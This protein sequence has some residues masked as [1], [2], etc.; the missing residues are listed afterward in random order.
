LI[1]F[2]NYKNTLLKNYSIRLYKPEDYALWNTFVN[3]SKNGTFLFNRDFMEYHHDR[4]DDFSLLIFDDK[5]KLVS[6]LP[7]NIKEETV[8]SHQGLTYGGLLFDGKIKITE[9]IEVF[10]TVML[11]LHENK[12]K[13]LNV[14]L[15][16]SVYHQKPANEIAYVLFLANAKL[17]RCD[18]LSVIDL[19]E[20]IAITSGRKEGIKKAEKLN[21][22]I[23][24]ESNFDIFWNQIL[25]PNLLKKHQTKPIHTLEEI[26]KLKQL[27]PENIRQFNVYQ[28]DRIVAGTTIFESQNV[29]HAQYI[30]GN[31]SK[32]ENG[33]L[34]FLYHELITKTFKDKKY[35]DFG[36]SNENQG[37]KLNSGLN[38]WKE[39]FGAST[40]VQDFYEV[41]TKTYNLL[42]DVLI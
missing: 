16:P 31:E 37:R 26:S 10:K 1:N 27:F 32:S 3:T 11:F 12:I 35:F 29:A 34:D 22:V 8:F 23:K 13:T 17:T 15:I 41:E 28:N 19:N 36:T 38:F 9:A 4:F 24:E 14:K 39:S 25:I 5:H 33:S 42:N 30:S 20:K 2:P 18:A 40:I 6:I 7:A 21:L